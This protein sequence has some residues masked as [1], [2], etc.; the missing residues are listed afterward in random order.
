[1]EDV[2]VK[3]TIAKRSRT[4]PVLFIVIGATFLGGAIYYTT[5]LSESRDR[6]FLLTFAIV[7]YVIAALLIVFSSRS[8]SK[9]YI[10]VEADETAV[11]LYY[12]SNKKPPVA[13]P[14]AELADCRMDAASAKYIGKPGTHAFAFRVIFSF[15][16]LYFYTAQKRYEIGYVQQARKA[17]LAIREE[18]EKHKEKTQSEA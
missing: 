6:A 15:G 12:G 11:Y 17:C 16:T 2:G 3:K 5:G 10:A 18:M 1:M 14:Y 8:L 4:L 13:I 7:Y 9:R